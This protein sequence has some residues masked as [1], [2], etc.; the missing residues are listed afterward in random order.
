MR[1]TKVAAPL[2]ALLVSTAGY[3][4]TTT[5]QQDPEDSGLKR[6]TVQLNAD[7]EDDNPTLRNSAMLARFGG[8]AKARVNLFNEAQKQRQLYPNLLP[9]GSA[10]G[11]TAW[12]SIGPTKTNRI[13]NGVTLHAVNSGRMRTILPHPT[14]PNT[15]YL[16]T[17][18]GGL[19]KT[20]NF[21]LQKPT[22]VAKTDALLTT[23]GGAASFGANPE[24]LYVG[25]GDPF[26]G[27]V[28]AGGVM[29]KS[30]NGGDT[31]SDPVQLQ[32]APGTNAGSIR[33][34]KVDSN[35]SDEVVLVA[36]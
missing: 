26:D 35:G 7:G 27:T 25:F 6:P 36:T 13:Q 24:T 17:S 23:S 10:S 18:S 28:Q 9:G 16:L 31:W 19:W 11:A 1:F 4:Q 12:T 15:V 21:N 33:D 22:W 2:L 29:V 34:V 8:T 5:P 20:T 14:D 32:L 30:T 3:T